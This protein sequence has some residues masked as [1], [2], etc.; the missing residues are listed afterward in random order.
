MRKLETISD[1]LATA[2]HDRLYFTVRTNLVDPK[3]RDQS[4]LDQRARDIVKELIRHLDGLDIR[5]PIG[6]RPR[7]SDRDFYPPDEIDVGIRA[8]QALIGRPD[9]MPVMNCSPVRREPS[10]V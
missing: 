4:I 5:R 2:I 8:K 3:V 9:L 6:R 7:H 10:D 1:E